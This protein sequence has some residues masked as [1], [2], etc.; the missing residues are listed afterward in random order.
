MTIE[1]HF[2]QIREK[3]QAGELDPTTTEIQIKASGHSIAATQWDL[4]VLASG[5]PGRI[6][7]LLLINIFLPESAQ[8]DL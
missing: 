6:A 3:L 7:P 8:L 1:E 5:D 4:H 2:A